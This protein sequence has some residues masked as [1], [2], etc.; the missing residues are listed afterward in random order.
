MTSSIE[1]P[2]AMKKALAREPKA[3]TVFD[4]LSYSHQKEY[5]LWINDAKREETLNRRLE[6]LTS[7]LLERARTKG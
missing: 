6:K 3:K 1:I 7:V 2:A 5:V 4:K